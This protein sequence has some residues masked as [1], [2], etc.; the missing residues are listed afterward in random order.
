MRQRVMIAMALALDPEVLIADEP[1]TALDVTVQAQIM[2]LLAELQRERNMGLILI[3][4]DLG[5]VA[6]VADQIA[7][8]YA[9][10]IVEP[11]PSTRCTAARAPV[12]AAGCS[13]R[14]RGWTRRARSSRDQGS[15]AEPD[16][17]PAGLPVQPALPDGPG[18]VPD[19]RAAAVLQVGD[20]TPGQRLPL[21]EGASMA[22]RDAAGCR[23][24]GRPPAPRP[25][26]R[27]ILEVRD[28]VKH[29]PLTQGVVFKKPSARSRP[30]TASRSTC[31]RRD[32]RHGR[33][34]RLR[35]V[36]PRRLLMGLEQP[37]AG[38]CSTRARTSPSCPARR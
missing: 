17:H 31:T 8:M 2:D 9:G 34:V 26:R 3:T 21:L 24:T 13:T 10:R 23:W 22:E 25:P 29:F 37:T 12:H 4:H 6:D 14:S 20:G 11:R 36:D 32:A 27:T 28:L 7:V 16:A 30:S 19:R 1:T 15:A 38:R 5:V 33:R 18:R 35:Q